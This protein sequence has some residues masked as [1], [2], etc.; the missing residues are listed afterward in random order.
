MTPQFTL[1]AVFLSG[2][3]VGLALSCVLQFML[4]RIKQ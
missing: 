2:V 3:V 4:W 1:W